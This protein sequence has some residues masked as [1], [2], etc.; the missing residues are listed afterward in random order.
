MLG[1]GRFTNAFDE[2][3]E[4]LWEDC[5]YAAIQPQKEEV[6]ELHKEKKSILPG[7]LTKKL[8]F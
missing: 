4:G 8:G 6:E 5:E 3:K 7:F 2:V 1:L